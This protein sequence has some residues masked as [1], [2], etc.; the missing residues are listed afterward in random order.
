MREYDFIAPVTQLDEGEYDAVILGVAHQQF[1]ISP[2]PKTSAS[3]GK[4]GH[5]LRPE[6]RVVARRIRICAC[7]RTSR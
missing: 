7:R 6:V 2:T 5:P 3:L 4:P 1:A